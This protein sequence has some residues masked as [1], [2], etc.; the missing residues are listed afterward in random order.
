MNGTEAPTSTRSSA[1]S[2][3]HAPTTDPDARDAAKGKLVALLQHLSLEERH[4]LMLHYAEE[5]E[6]LEISLVLD[7]SVMEIERILGALRQRVSHELRAAG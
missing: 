6:P 2:A 3:S 1:E 4:V 7:I 5:L